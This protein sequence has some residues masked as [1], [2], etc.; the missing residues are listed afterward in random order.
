[1]LVNEQVIW[2]QVTMGRDESTFVLFVNQSSPVNHTPLV[3]VL[4]AKYDLRN[5]VLGP[6]LW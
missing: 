1:M 3:Q 2:L 6:L 5:V 4:Q